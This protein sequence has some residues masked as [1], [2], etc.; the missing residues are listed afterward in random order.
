LHAVSIAGRES[1]RR[2][3]EM[4]STSTDKLKRNARG[5]LACC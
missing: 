5:H 4:R 1:L 2:R 3:H